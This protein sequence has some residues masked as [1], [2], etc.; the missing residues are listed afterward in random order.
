MAGAPRPARRSPAVW[1]C[2]AVGLALALAG[3]LGF[4]VDAT[5]D[6]QATG[7]PTAGS[8]NANGRLQGDGLLGFE[9][10]GWHNVV[11]LASGLLLLLLA[12]RHARVTALAFGALYAV[13]ALVGIVNGNDVLGII[14]VNAAD[15]VLHVVLAIAGLATGLASRE[16]WDEDGPEEGEGEAHDADAARRRPLRAQRSAPA[17]ESGGAIRRRARR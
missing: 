13:V 1:Y 6:T 17:P 2:L 7:D 14:P 5:F 15:N 16:E 8:G 10:N 11:H 9:V 3:L 12:R 4:L